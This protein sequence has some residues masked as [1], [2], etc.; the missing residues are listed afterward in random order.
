MQSNDKYG[1]TDLV[2]DEIGNWKLRRNCFRDRWQ[3]VLNEI[4]RDLLFS[5]VSKNIFVKKIDFKK[6]IVQ[7][8]YTKKVLLFA[9]MHEFNVKY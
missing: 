8:I 5:E 7:K 4:A 1:R 6:K 3:K 2:L 9:Q